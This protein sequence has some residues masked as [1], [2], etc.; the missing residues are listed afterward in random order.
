[1]SESLK[2]HSGLELP[3]KTYLVSSGRVKYSLLYK[4]QTSRNV[5]EKTTHKKKD[6][7]KII[8]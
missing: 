5:N 4:K 8:L 7:N 2:A 6:K 3:K 1:M